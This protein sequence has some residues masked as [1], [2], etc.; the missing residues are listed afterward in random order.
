M[1]N[2]YVEVVNASMKPFANCTDYDL[3]LYTTNS[4]QSIVFG[5]SNSSSN[6]WVK[7]SNSN[8]QIESSLVLGSAATSYNICAGNLGMFRNRIINGDMRID[9]RNAG[10]AV[11]FSTDVNVYTIDRFASVRNAAG[12]PTGL[13]FSVQRSNI[14]FAVDGF[15]YALG[16]TVTTASSTALA[17]G[18]HIVITDHRIE[19]FN[20]ADL[21][22][23]TANAKPATISFWA[24][25]NGAYTYFLSLRNDGFTRSYVTSLATTA[26]TWQLYTFTIPGDTTGTWPKDNTVGLR[27]S[28]SAVSGSTFQTS[29]ANV[30]QAGNFMS[31]TTNTNA[32]ISTVNANFLI[33]GLQLE[34]GPVAT[35][36][37]IRPFG[38][39]LQLCQRY[40]EKSYVYDVVPGYAYTMN[41]NV[42]D[43]N[44]FSQVT[45]NVSLH[46]SYNGADFYTWGLTY[47]KTTKRQAPTFSIY[48]P[49]GVANTFWN[50]N[51]CANLG[52]VLLTDSGNTG[53][54]S[55]IVRNNTASVSLTINNLYGFHWT[56]NSE[57]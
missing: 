43:G 13:V 47:M 9:Q 24:R 40:Y 19:G 5:A 11:S 20:V 53:T 26:N 38:N 52:S 1:S 30:W 12:G 55:F 21:Q 56:A 25:A 50:F 44:R 49:N 22:W 17:A 4:N 2:A 54:N 35:P 18:N 14:D 27:V 10:A 34:K 36:F 39:E 37:E 32:F 31:L 28:I 42:S 7:M 57:L 33:T 46:W 23:G 6:A 41:T 15:Q 3:A 45:P 8:V 16:F 29:S 51:T 48:S